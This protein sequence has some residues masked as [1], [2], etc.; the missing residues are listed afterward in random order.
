MRQVI[1]IHAHKDL[2]QLNA[3]VGRLLDDEFLIYVNVDAKSAIDVGA[4]HPAAR[5]VRPRIDIGWGD[6][7]QVEATLHSMRQVA[8]EAGEFDKLVFISAQDY[9]LLSNQHFKREL[10]AL[11]G[12]ELL[13]C[14]PVGAEGWHCADRYRYFHRDGGGALA[15]LACSL[16][17]RAMRAG[18][19]TR[20]MVNGWQ[21]WGGS[22]WW[23]LS[24]G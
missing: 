18:G 19:L 4:L 3:L 15:R 13:D 12:S 22:S 24:R 10:A 11:A 14:V 5:L 7:T 1:L 20:R 17:N 23:A 21:A 6:F 9:P 8:L 2:N 16:A